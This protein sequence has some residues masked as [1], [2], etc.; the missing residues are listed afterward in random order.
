MHVLLPLLYLLC[1]ARSSSFALRMAP[2]ASLSRGRRGCSTLLAARKA[3][4]S[5]AW[6]GSDDEQP[7]E[8]GD[9]GAAEEGVE[10]ENG[11]GSRR[12][13]AAG[14]DLSSPRAED[15]VQNRDLDLILSERSKRFYD[16]EIVKLEKEK[17]LL[18]AVDVMSRRFETKDEAGTNTNG[19]VSSVF[20]L[21]ESLSEL[22]ELV[23]TA[24][25]QV[26]GSC[27]QKL[28]VPNKSTYVG[29][30]KVDDI[31]VLVNA[32]NAKTIVVDDDLTAKQQRNLESLFGSVGG[33]D[34]KILDRTALI[35]EIFAQHATSREGQ[36]QVELAML[37][38]RLTRGPRASG[39]ADR[40]S[41]AGFRGNPN[42]NPNP[43]VTLT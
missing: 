11:M 19:Y 21:Q 23:G 25:L 37:E 1:L 36:L 6:K 9:E 22:S 8:G 28:N 2:A 10:P 14:P 38:Y 16:P 42:P 39:D 12:G 17:C 24:G 7:P 15:L 31:M 43:D 32:T 18:V 29:P 13:S 5:D 26:M 30:G 34:V 27:V 3:R 33:G 35:L 20:S 41:G 4:V 40:D